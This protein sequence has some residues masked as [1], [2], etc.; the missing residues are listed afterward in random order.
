MTT[1][2]EEFEYYLAHEDD[3]FKKYDGKFIVLKEKE[4]I[5]VYTSRREAI[6]QTS[7]E[8]APGTFLVQHV[9][10]TEGH[11]RFHSRVAF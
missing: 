8:H 6:E 1:L 9:S 5:G 3:F 7:T 11:A 10:A 4:V 2:K